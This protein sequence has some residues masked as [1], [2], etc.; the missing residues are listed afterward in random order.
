MSSFSGYSSGEIKIIIL[1]VSI[2]LLVGASHGSFCAALIGALIGGIGLFA[3]FLTVVFICW[4][5]GA[6]IIK[7]KGLKK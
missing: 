4:A 5:T 6:A 3:A 2:G 1:G 7:I